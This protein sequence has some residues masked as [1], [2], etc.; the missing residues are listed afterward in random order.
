MVTSDNSDRYEQLKNKEPVLVS[1]INSKM[2]SYQYGE[3][4]I[5]QFGLHRF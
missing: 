4:L 2:T 3:N 1:F 5:L